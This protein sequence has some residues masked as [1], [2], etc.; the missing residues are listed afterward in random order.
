MGPPDHQT[1]HRTVRELPGVSVSISIRSI[2]TPPRRHFT[3]GTR[4]RALSVSEIFPREGLKAPD[5]NLIHRSLCLLEPIQ[6]VEIYGQAIA[7]VKRR[8]MILIIARR[9]KAAT[10]LA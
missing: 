4:R 5:G 9:M 1:V 3:A 10:V 2:I 6:E 8:S 7:L